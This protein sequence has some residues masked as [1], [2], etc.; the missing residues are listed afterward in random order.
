M[1]YYNEII[2]NLNKLKD[3]N[4]ENHLIE[5]KNY[6]LNES[7]K[8][9]YLILAEWL[10]QQQNLSFYIYNKLNPLIYNLFNKLKSSSLLISKDLLSITFNI[11]LKFNDSEYQILFNSIYNENLELNLSIHQIFY[12]ILLN[13]EI[14]KI[15]I[16]DIIILNEKFNDLSLEYKIVYSICATIEQKKFYQFG[17]ERLSKILLNINKDIYQ[18]YG[19]ILISKISNPS[20]ELFHEIVL[21]CPY[22]GSLDNARNSWN[23]SL[24][25]LNQMNDQDKFN[26]LLKSLE[27][28]NLPDSTRSSIT[29]QIMKEMSNSNKN[30]LFKSPFLTSLINL[31]LI[32]DFKINIISKSESLITSL[33][34]IRLLILLDKKFNCYGLN[35]N[36]NL[37][38]DIMNSLKK[39]IKNFKKDNEKPLELILKDL[40]KSNL[41]KNMSIED[42]K[43]S[44]KNNELTINR[45]NH[46]IEIIEILIQQ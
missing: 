20:R 40:K 27:D 26:C 23:I 22:F 42:V 18:Y 10:S 12:L 36:I 35:S 28:P 15:F 38:I 46:L 24:N 7:G 11:F 3:E 29:T 45:I 17:L 34:F 44:I 43:N 30:S 25:I 14:S 13:P 6:F 21:K 33:N 4:S 39:S 1:D 41:T 8:E 2:N 9:I 19:V 32:E 31:I 37:I 5:L 16:N